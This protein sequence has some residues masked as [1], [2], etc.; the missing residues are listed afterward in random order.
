M[1]KKLQI[2]E[3]LKEK[4]VDEE[5]NELPRRIERRLGDLESHVLP[6]HHRSFVAVPASP[7]AYILTRIRDENEEAF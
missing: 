5:K 1:S 3:G 4:R 7:I 2:T 6:L